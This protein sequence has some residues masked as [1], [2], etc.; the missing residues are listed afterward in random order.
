MDNND[1]LRRLRYAFDF[2]DAEAC[3]LFTL[4]PTSS[5]AVSKKQL[6]ARLSKQEEADFEVCEDAELAAFLDGLIVS[7]RGL[8]ESATEA[9]GALKPTGATVP[10]PDLR[11]S[12]N[13][14]LKKLRIAMNFREDDMLAVLKE[15]GS[16]LSKSELGAFFRKPGHKHFRACGNQVLR[17]F[18][19]G[20]TKRNREVEG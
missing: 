1:I 8:K 14:I 17:N 4:D 7:K 18:I 10:A 20:L 13:D 12:R 6:K 3:K 5:Q 16:E 15:G 2:S 11:L 19:V 9:A